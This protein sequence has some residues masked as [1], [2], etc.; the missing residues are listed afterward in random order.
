MAGGTL[1]SGDGWRETPAARAAT[2]RRVDERLTQGVESF[3]AERIADRGSFT[4]ADLAAAVGIERFDERE[5]QLLLVALKGQGRA[6]CD[7]AGWHATPSP[8]A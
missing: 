8:D 5:A 6:D 7:W 1:A 3:L 2:H 4:S